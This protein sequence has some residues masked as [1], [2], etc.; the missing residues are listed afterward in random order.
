MN[1]RKFLKSGVVAGT[2]ATA[3]IAAPNVVTAQAKTFSW[4]M[5]NA[6]GPGAPARMN[7]STASANRAGCSTCGR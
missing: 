1:R 6:Y 3:A 2:A 4:K 7:S 5:T